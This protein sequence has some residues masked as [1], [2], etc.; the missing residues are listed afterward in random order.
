VV[1]EEIQF[2]QIK[3]A[4]FWIA[5]KPGHAEGFQNHPHMQGMFFD[6]VR[7]NNDIVH[8]DMAYFTDVLPQSGGHSSLVYRW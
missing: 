2:Q 1:S 8:V 6:G 4:F 5:V 7:P 3:G